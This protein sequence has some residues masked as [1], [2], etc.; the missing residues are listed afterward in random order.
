MKSFPFIIILSIVILGFSAHGQQVVKC[1]DK[2]ACLKELQQDKF[3][4]IDVRTPQEFSKGHL[5]NALNYNYYEADFKEKINALDRKQ[6]VLVYCEVGGRSAD[7]VKQ[8]KS[9]GF[10]YIIE[11]KGGYR[12]WKNT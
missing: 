10:D 6:K 8:F 5:E 4:I 9:L 7:A 2:S 12:N 11:I 1:L 3:L